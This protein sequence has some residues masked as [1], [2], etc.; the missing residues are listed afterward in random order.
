MHRWITREGAP[1]S[2]AVLPSPHSPGALR[3]A[4]ARLRRACR[5]VR[6]RTARKRRRWCG[7]AMAEM[8]TGDGVM[9]VLVCHPG[10]AR[11]E[12]ADVLRR[13]WPAAVVQDVG[14]AEPSWSMPTEDAAELA[15]VR[16]GVEPL[17]IV[18][19]PQSAADPAMLG[20]TG[21]APAAMVVEPMPI[22]S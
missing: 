20:L 2:L 15:R 12:V 14:A 16:R 10:V 11:S 22:V 9:L 19:L 21:A 3:A 6:D 1:D 4:V 17:R 13:R 18:V 5:D 7:V 8:A